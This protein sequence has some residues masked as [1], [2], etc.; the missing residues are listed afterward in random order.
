MVFKVADPFLTYPSVCDGFSVGDGTLAQK[1]CP[2]PAL[3]FYLVSFSV[4]LFVV[5]SV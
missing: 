5:S 4:L 3:N 2:S 1:T